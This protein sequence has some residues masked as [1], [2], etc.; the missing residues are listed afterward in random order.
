MLAQVGRHV[1][2]ADLLV[3]VTLAG[4]QRLLGHRK[5][6][7]KDLR[8]DL[9]VL[10]IIRER[11]QGQR[12][13]ALLASLDARDDLGRVVGK[14][15][16]VT[17]VQALVGQQAVA[18]VVIGVDGQQAL[19][20]GDGFVT[21]FEFRQDDAAVA[22]GGFVVGLDGQ[23]T[24]EALQRFQVALLVAQQHTA[25]EQHFG[26]F[27]VELQRLVVAG[28]GVGRTA[29][30]L[31]HVGVSHPQ[32]REVGTRRHAARQQFQRLGMVASLQQDHRQ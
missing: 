20:H 17:G 14:T 12:F 31:Q 28:H 21:S 25:V 24:L 29:K 13:A 23:H 19:E 2:Q 26:V 1:G 30:R 3:A 9:V 4:P 16:P 8:A 22:H 5:A 6:R 32:G 18:I 27:G 10:A 11:H 7:G 15:G